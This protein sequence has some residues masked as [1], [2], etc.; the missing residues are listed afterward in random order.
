[1]FTKHTKIQWAYE[2]FLDVCKCLISETSV[3]SILTVAHNLNAKDLKYV[4][5][6]FFFVDFFAKFCALG[7]LV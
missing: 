3:T 5:T 1:M 6:F 2:L 4:V 7:I